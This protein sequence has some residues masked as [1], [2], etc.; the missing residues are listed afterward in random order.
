MTVGAPVVLAALV[1]GVIMAIFQAITQVNE[2][3][4]GFVPKLGAC[5]GVIIIGSGWMIDSLMSFTINLFNSIPVVIQ[6]L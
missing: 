5:A 1:V 2:Q 6:S 3:S 4:L